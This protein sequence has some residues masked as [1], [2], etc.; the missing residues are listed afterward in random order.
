MK[1]RRIFTIVIACILT[2]FA[3]RAVIGILAGDLAY[4]VIPGWH[5]IIYPPEMTLTM[6]TGMLLILTLMVVGL[7]KTLS[8]FISAVLNR[9]VKKKD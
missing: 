2:F 7:Y 8:L 5:T 3:T 6:L 1:G 9:I 4:S